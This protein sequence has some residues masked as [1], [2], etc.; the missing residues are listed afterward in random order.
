MMKRNRLELALDRAGEGTHP[1]VICGFRPTTEDVS[2]KTS[3]Y[4]LAMLSAMPAAMG[5]LKVSCL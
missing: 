5:T 3:T 2:C 1:Y 4:V